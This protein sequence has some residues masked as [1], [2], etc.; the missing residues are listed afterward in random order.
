MFPF[1]A[2]FGEGSILGRGLAR[3]SAR[4][5]AAS[6]LVTRLSSITT[7]HANIFDSL[8][9][10]LR[11]ATICAARAPRWLSIVGLV[12]AFRLI[13]GALWSAVG[14]QFTDF[15]QGT[16]LQ[17]R[18][19]LVELRPMI[20]SV[21]R[22]PVFRLLRRMLIWGAYL[23]AIL[24]GVVSVVIAALV[25]TKMSSFWSWVFIVVVS[26]AVTHVENLGTE[27]IYAKAAPKLTPPNEIE[28][29]RRMATYLALYPQETAAASPLLYAYSALTRD[30][31]EQRFFELGTGKVSLAPR[32]I[33]VALIA[34]IYPHI[35]APDIEPLGRAGFIGCTYTD[36]YG[37]FRLTQENLPLAIVAAALL[38]AVS[39]L[40]VLLTYVPFMREWRFPLTVQFEVLRRDWGFAKRT[41]LY[42]PL[43]AIGGAILGM[44][45]LWLSAL[46]AT[47]L[48]S[49]VAGLF[50][51]LV[52]PLAVGFVFRKRI[53]GG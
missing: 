12:V 45:P 3:W 51:L 27:R 26:F 32:L 50:V 28:A 41:M 39:P 46:L 47:R 20:Y 21:W 4:L 43:L 49:A 44:A 15:Q 23:L 31:L 13:V 38:L 29:L 2:K 53:V 22:D 11:D 25:L 6:F 9:N 36:L 7:P 19:S 1:V 18:R 34:A 17:K 48:N 42:Q 52:M 24:S 40:T 30:Q 10:Q 35:P 16:I 14:Q 5:L 8:A 37:F 33:T